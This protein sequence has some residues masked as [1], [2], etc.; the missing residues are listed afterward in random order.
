MKVS[1][2]RW[3]KAQKWESEWHGD[4]RNTYGEEEKQ[5]TYARKMGL[6]FFHNGKSPYNIDLGGKHVLD[7]GGG[8]CS[9]LL[10]CLNG[11]GAVADPVLKT[12]P[13]WVKDRYFQSGIVSYPLKGEEIKTEYEYDEVWIYNVLQHVQDPKRIIKTARKISKLVRVF[14]WLGIADEVGHPHSLTQEDLNTWL[15]GE[16]QVEMLNDYTLKGLC[17]YGVFLGELY[18]QNS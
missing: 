9:L 1:T 17:Y 14:E 11:N 15:G 4:C 7:I 6:Q 13:T 16:G 3:Q 5:L 2:E 12:V 18:E 10:K 8:P